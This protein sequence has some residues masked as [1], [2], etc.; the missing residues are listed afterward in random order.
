[1]TNIIVHRNIV[2]ICFPG[3]EKYVF[4]MQ[5][6]SFF[7]TVWL[8]RSKVGNIEKHCFRR[9]HFHIHNYILCVILKKEHVVCIP[10]T[11]LNQFRDF[12]RI[13]MNIMP[14]E[15]TQK[16]YSLFP[17][18]IYNTV[19]HMQACKVVT[20]LAPLNFQSWNDMW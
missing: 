15:A 4:I 13:G 3:G 5:W 7:S 20:K 17:T 19:A 11:F 1:M 16:M 14:S 9:K 10:L 12:H 2:T 8:V 6:P 18:I